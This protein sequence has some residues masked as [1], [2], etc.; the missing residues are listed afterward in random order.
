MDKE[1]T[2]ESSVSHTDFGLGK[3]PIKEGSENLIGVW[4]KRGLG[5]WLVIRSFW[6]S[7]DSAK[8]GLAGT[9]Y[10]QWNE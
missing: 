7:D 8:F 1:I 2:N 6:E 3:A 4:F 10:N 9:N 5:D